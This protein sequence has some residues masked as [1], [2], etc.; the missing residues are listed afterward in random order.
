[1]FDISVQYFLFCFD[2]FDPLD[3]WKQKTLPYI[4]N[5][6]SLKYL[7][8]EIWKP[9]ETQKTRNRCLVSIIKISYY[10]NCNRSNYLHWE[11]P[12]MPIFFSS[13]SIRRCEESSLLGK[14]MGYWSKSMAQ[15]RHQSI[16]T[17]ILWWSEGNWLK[18][19]YCCFF[20]YII[21]YES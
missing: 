15:E 13:R 11:A 7:I 17:Q 6:I 4:T 10:W 14:P 19:F 3:D 20:I 1:M 12:L 16:F 18:L 21:F 2:N 5:S 8:N 9:K